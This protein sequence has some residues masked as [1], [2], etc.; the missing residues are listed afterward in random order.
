MGFL[1]ITL[2]FIG[3]GA[4]LSVA[5]ISSVIAIG[6]MPLMLNFSWS[7]VIDL[8]LSYK[9]WCGIGMCLCAGMLV[10]L[11]AM[12][13]R[14]GAV[15]LITLAAFVLMTGS[16]LVAIPLGGLI[17]HGVP[18]ELKGKAAGCYQVGNMAGIGVG[19]GGGLWLASRSSTPVTAGLVLALL[20]LTCLVGVYAA[21]E[22]PRLVRGGVL[23][24]VT[25]IGRELWDIVREPR[26]TLVVALVVTPIGL[27]AANNLWSAVAGE[28]H[29]SAN[30]IALVTGVAGACVSAIG[31]A[32]GGWWADRA[33]RRIVY[34]ASGGILAVVGT[35]LAVTP[36]TPVL[37]TSGTLSY[38]MTV[39]ICNAAF[40]ALVLSTIGRG[41]AASKFAIISGLGN[42][43]TS[44]MTALDGWIHDRSGSGAMLITEAGICILLITVGAVVLRNVRA[45]GLAAGAEHAAV[46]SA[47]SPG[48]EP[49]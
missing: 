20:S 31:C 23:Q 10:L 16:T 24:K 45:L 38:G 4:G 42:F 9:Q 18:E 1:T 43:P 49:R 8:T 22:P 47:L 6:L 32:I 17:A 48:G 2:P 15:G 13:L 12:P 34:L 11:S 21:E 41:A 30:T 28:W 26:G 36:R 7:P 33:D 5:A 14:P 39:G 27:G 35:I 44:Y 29:V 25:G 19:G 37:F 46:Q 3:R 40:S